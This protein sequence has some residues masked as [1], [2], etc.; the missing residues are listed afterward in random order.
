MTAVTHRPVSRSLVKSSVN[1]GFWGSGHFVQG[2]A[3]ALYKVPRRSP[4]ARRGCVLPAPRSPPLGASPSLGGFGN[5]SPKARPSLVDLGRGLG[6][7]R[8]VS[9]EPLSEQACSAPA[10][11]AHPR[12]CAPPL[13]PKPPQRP[14]NRTDRGAGRTAPS[15]AEPRSPAGKSAS[16]GS[17][18]TGARKSVSPFSLLNVKKRQKLKSWLQRKMIFKDGGSASI[19]WD[20]REW[21]A[22]GTLVALRTPHRHAA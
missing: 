15:G 4:G 10:S 14:R 13:R 2:R 9:A 12:T 1:V 7:S 16:C 18:E 22:V 8:A 19:Q 20:G 6:V 21:T 3:N 5:P 11:T 17:W